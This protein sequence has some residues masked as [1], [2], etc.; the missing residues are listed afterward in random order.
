MLAYSEEFSS[1]KEAFRREQQVKKWTRAKKEALMK[2]NIAE[3]KRLAKCRRQLSKSK[4][5]E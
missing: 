2:G 1:Y 4:F 3:L 5:E